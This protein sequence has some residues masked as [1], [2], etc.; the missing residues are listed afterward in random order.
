MIMCS[1]PF[2]YLGVVLLMKC[3]SCMLS[4]CLVGWLMHLLGECCAQTLLQYR[5][6]AQP[7]NQG[8]ENFNFSTLG[9]C[10]TPHHSDSHQLSTHTHI[11]VIFLFSFS[12][13][14]LSFFT[15]PP[16][17]SELLSFCVLVHLIHF[18]AFFL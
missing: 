14:R 1:I 5:C 8:L 16:F 10:C 2:I 7:S 12:Q 4:S 6:M 3:V 17:F 18:F 13:S 9:F 11:L 15:F